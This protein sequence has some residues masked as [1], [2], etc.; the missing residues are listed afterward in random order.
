MRIFY[1]HQYFVT[2]KTQGGTRSYEFA[3]YLAQKGHDV[4]VITSGLLN[5]QFPVSPK[6]N[7]KIYEYKGF[8]VAAIP[9]GYADARRGTSFSGRQRMIKFL[10]FARQA[11]KVG[12]QL[13]SP[14]IVF[15]THTP[16]TIGYAG[17]KLATC[18]S[19]PFIFEVRD[20]W[21]EA[22]INIGVLN[23]PLV[24]R[25]FR[26]L[27]N[28]FYHSADHI[29]AL[30]PGMKQG[31]LK[32]GI[33]SSKVTVIPNA[34]DLDLFQP[35][36]KNSIIEEKINGRF[37]AIYFGAMGKANGLDY[38]IDA[39]RLL[40]QQGNDDI[41]F[42]LHGDGSERQD[43]QRTVNNEKLNNVLFSDPV[44]EKTELAAIISQCNVCMTIYKA[45]NEQTWSP[46]KMFD[47]LAAGKPVLVN[48]GGWLGETIEKHQCGY[49]LDPGRPAD[50]A[51]AVKK[52]STNPQQVDE[53]GENARRL[54]EREFDR[55]K[56]AQK[57]E[58]VFVN[59]AN[60]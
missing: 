44:S 23:N 19:V 60:P 5:S 3:K 46:N 30:S 57:L 4:T 32:Y 34:S 29:V 36:I 38:V 40:K 48:V 1:L 59:M 12:K 27:A 51:D 45:T 16:L 22:L 52:L 14:D 31:I 54:A 10:Q 6:N 13:S 2:P 11:T 41:V 42:I 39:A 53:M 25:Y 24:I 15:A 21:P 43:L 35:E 17:E 20:L 7:F 33:S 56:L 49:Q 9:A 26:Y 47:A 50:L 55:R 58:D 8:K 28:R 18:F 37:S